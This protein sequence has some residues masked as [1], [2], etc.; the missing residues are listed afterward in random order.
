[1]LVKKSANHP[2]TIKS[3]KEYLANKI[4]IADDIKPEYENL[5]HDPQTSGGLLISVSPEKFQNLLERLS[6]AGVQASVVGEVAKKRDGAVII[7][8]N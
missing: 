8:E 2:K 6:S 4:K 1:E 5:L 3:N 7:V